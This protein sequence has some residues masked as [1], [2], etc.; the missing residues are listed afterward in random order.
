M[1]EDEGTRTR[2]EPRWPRTMPQDERD[3]IM[4][5]HYGSSR[6]VTEVIPALKEKNA[7][8]T[9]KL[10]AAE[11][12]FIEPLVDRELKLLK[13]LGFLPTDSA[14]RKKIP[15][16]TGCIDYFP[17]ALAAVAE[18]SRIGNDKHNP[19]QPLH[20]AREKSADHADCLMRHFVERGKMD[21]KVR[22]STEV[23]WRAL[24]LLQLEIEGAAK[25]VDDFKA[26]IDQHKAPF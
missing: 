9:A 15:L 20:W 8:Q 24:A 17:N 10:E 13:D 22:H 1:S 12:K 23:A 4:E 6:M 5:E 2:I 16:A 21:G 26:K 14:A 25:V 19:G 18:L 3:A 11:A 7:M